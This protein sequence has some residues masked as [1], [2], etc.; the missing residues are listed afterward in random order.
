[1]G[2]IWGTQGADPGGGLS[3]AIAC[4]EGFRAWKIRRWRGVPVIF[5]IR[6]A[7]QSNIIRDGI[8]EGKNATSLLMGRMRE[9]SN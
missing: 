1:M 3:G 6:D 2:P 5:N 8:L 9:N 7:K 4:E